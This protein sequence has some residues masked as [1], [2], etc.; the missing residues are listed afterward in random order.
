VLEHL[1]EP[2]RFLDQ[3]RTLLK[4]GG[5]CFALVPNLDSLAMRLLGVRYRY[6]YSQ[7]LNYF[8]KTTL[9][10][11]VGGPFSVIEFR[12]MHFNPVV[13]WQD[14]RRGGAEVSNQERAEL[15]KRTT[16]YKQNPLLKPVKGLYRIAERTLGGL[17]LAD[18]LAVVARKTRTE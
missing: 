9:A 2:R 10:K 12:S 6:I 3:A 8:S 5:L 11:L 18:N 17:G 4:P 15:L 16:A 1:A 14:W 7:H 13:I